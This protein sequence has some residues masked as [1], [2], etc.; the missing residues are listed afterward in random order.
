VIQ[1]ARRDELLEQAAEASRTG[2]RTRQQRIATSARPI[3][4]SAVAASL[5]W[6]VA[7]EVVGHPRPFFAPISA[8]VTLGLTVGQRRRRAVELAIGVA[9][10][11]AI[12]DAL[13]AAI[14]T[15]TW[16]V[17]VV[18][19]LAMGAAT[20]VGGGPL[21]ASQAG[22]SAV[23]VATLQ[24]PDGG[25]DFGRAVD[26]L[27]GSGSALLVS[28]LLLP[29]NPRRLLRESAGPVLDQLVGALERLSEALTARR[30]EATEAAL[31]T[32]ARADGV[33]D[34]LVAALEPAGEAI[35]LSPQRR[36]A[37]GDLDR[38]AVAAVPVGRLIE[39]IRSLARGARRAISVDDSVP[40][41]AVQAIDELT[42]ATRGLNRYLDDGDPEPTS[43]AAT[44]AAALANAVLEATGNLSA[45]HIVGQIRLAAVDLLRA[46]GLPRPEA[47]EAVRGARLS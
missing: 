9:V 17:G 43:A 40:P 28:S 16:Q 26:A 14:G 38:Y 35:Q 18:V 21:L 8:V 45:V 33:H 6:W 39:D 36:R 24:P 47:Q 1:R 44:R 11:I 27:V 41:E 32:L 12:A 25:V 20:L 23:L 30:L 19:A 22:A 15:G 42:A 46:T 31:E 3:L 4:H 29:L 2:L 10:G 34:A 13:V 37:L 7:T 5:A